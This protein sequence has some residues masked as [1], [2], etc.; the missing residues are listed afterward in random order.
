MEEKEEEEEEQKEMV[1]PHVKPVDFCFKLTR[2]FIQI[3]LVK[4]SI[5][6]KNIYIY[7]SMNFKCSC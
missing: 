4:S 6:I 5:I 7:N 1:E 3:N 2:E